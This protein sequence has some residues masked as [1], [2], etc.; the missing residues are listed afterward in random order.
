MEKLSS[1]PARPWVGQALILVTALL[2]STAGIFV[3]LLPWGPLS[4][5]CVRGLISAATL[6]V[7]RCI[8]APGNPKPKLPR[9]S[10]YNLLCGAAMFSTSLLFVAA[11]KMT[12]AANAIVLQ[13]IAPI[14]VLLYGVVIEKKRP[15]RLEILLTLV[16]FGGCALAF[17]D[18][19]GGNILGD[20]LALLSGFTF[21]AQ[22]LL[23]RNPKTS[24]EDAQLFGCC[25]SFALLFPFLWGDPQFRLTR[26]AIGVVVLLGVFQYGLASF[27]FAKGIR[28]TEPLSASIILTI[29]PIFSPVWVFAILGE[30][31]SL[32]ALLGFLCVIGAVT[33]YSLLPF[34]RSRRTQMLKG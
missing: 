3:K 28:R 33:V 9:L 34:L 10:L 12:T 27:F 4:I 18:Q 2:W 7:L 21:A 20:V 19:L 24:P 15:T 26:D 30:L 22:I 8:P 17:A 23:S 5:A 13:Y 14:V 1:T 16:V 25:M 6:L 31:P 11:N 29:E 32:T